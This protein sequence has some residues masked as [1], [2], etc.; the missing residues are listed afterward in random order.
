MHNV[1]YLAC[2]TVSLGRDKDDL[3]CTKP[4]QAQLRIWLAG[5]AAL[6]GKWEEGVVEVLGRGVGNGT[7]VGRI[8]LALEAGMFE[9]LY[10]V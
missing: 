8:V 4:G 3:S 10:C 7:W 9:A 2:A 5:V 6:S 1:F